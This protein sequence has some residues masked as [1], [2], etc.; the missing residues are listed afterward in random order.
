[1]F[2]YNIYFNWRI[3]LCKRILPMFLSALLIFTAMP[4]VVFAATMVTPIEGVTVTD[5]VGNGTLSN[6]VVTI[7]AKGGYLSQTTNTIT[8]ANNSGTTKKL[9][10]SYSASNYS[11]FSESAASGTIS[12]TLAAGGTVIITIKGYFE[13]Y[14]NPHFEQFCF[15]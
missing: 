14:C 2:T 5:S 6:G 8:I 13:Q 4:A 12:E 11:S 3:K 7:Q 15:G 10:F 1:M 9:S